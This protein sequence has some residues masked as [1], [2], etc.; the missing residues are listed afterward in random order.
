MPGAA[1]AW[2][3]N[4][5]FLEMN[6]R[7]G[8]QLFHYAWARYIMLKTGDSD[9]VI[10]YQPVFAG[11]TPE[12]GWFDCLKAYR[13]VNYQYYCKD[14]TIIKNETS[15]IQKI[16]CGIKYIHVKKYEKANRAI[17]AQ[18]AQSLQH[19]LNGGSILA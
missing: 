18:K 10:N 2:L 9:L 5:V 1:P 11:G 3:I 14:G 4:M 12:N 7:C 17:R 16:L 13:T 6:G 19:M 8:N 15:L